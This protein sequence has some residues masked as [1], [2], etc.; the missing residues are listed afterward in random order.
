MTEAVLER[1]SS[2]SRTE[3]SPDRARMAPAA[4]RTNRWMFQQDLEDYM[5]D[6]ARY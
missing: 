6:G 3:A 2:L 5:P 4:Y 1:I